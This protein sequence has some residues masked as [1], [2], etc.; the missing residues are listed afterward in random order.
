MKCVKKGKEVK[1]VS[2]KDAERMVGYG[3]DSRIPGEGWKYCSRSEW[4]KTVRDA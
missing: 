3:K 2:D 1:R 4:K